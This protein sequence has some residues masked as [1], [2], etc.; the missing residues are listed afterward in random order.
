MQLAWDSTLVDAENVLGDDA[1]LSTA[2]QTMT[3]QGTTYARS[4]YVGICDIYLTANSTGRCVSPAVVALPADHTKIVEFFR[5][6]V[7]ITWPDSTCVQAGAGICS[8]VA[9]TLISRA[10][11]PTFEVHRPAPLVKTTAV[12]LYQGQTSNAQIEA[13]GGQLPNTWIITGTMATGISVSSDGS[14]AGA[15]TVTGTWPIRATVTDKLGRSDT[16]NIVIN[17]VAPPRLNGPSDLKDHVG[18]A[19]NQ[20][21]TTA[22]GTMPFTYDATGLPRGLSIN[23][24]T[25]AITGMVTTAG[26]YRIMAK[27]TDINGGTATKSWTQIVYP[28]VALAAIADQAIAAPS[29]LRVAVLGSAG[30]GTLTYSATGLP[31]G[32]ELDDGTGAISGQPTSTGRYLPTVT[33]SDGLGGSAGAAA[34]QFEL[35]VTAPSSLTFTS[36]A[37][38]IVDRT[39]LAGAATSISFATNGATLGISPVLTATGLPPGLILNTLT[40]S[41]SGTP[42]TPGTYKVTMVATGGTPPQVSNLA[43]LWKIT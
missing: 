1:P 4:I 9:S 34:R 42:T 35:V 39:S 27:V 25:G 33:V 2:V 10:P 13:L 26:T 31:P 3:A 24:S 16:E 36:P 8:Y 23:S 11:E 17:V 43:F 41:V 37:F 32:V 14:I 30:G 6:V 18:E 20:V 29:T 38:A 5:V 7:L 21:V 15:P 19:V 28:A 12:T 22:G 40:S